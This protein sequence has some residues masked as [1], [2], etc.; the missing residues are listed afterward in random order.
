MIR[1]AISRERPVAHNEVPPG[2][3]AV[4][5]TAAAGPITSCGDLGT[6]IEIAG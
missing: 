4:D 3:A 5:T 1:T 2:T 6:G